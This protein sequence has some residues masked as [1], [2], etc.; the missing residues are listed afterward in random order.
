MGNWPGPSKP[1]AWM[2]ANSRTPPL[3]PGNQGVG[4]RQTENERMSSFSESRRKLRALVQP[5]EPHEDDCA[6]RLRLA[7]SMMDAGIEMTKLR[8]SRQFPME[9]EM[10][11]RQRLERWMQD[12][13][14]SDVFVPRPLA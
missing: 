8:L 4:A 6:S 13:P 2:L 12:Q 7:L 3:C 14:Y 1:M 9:T 5:Y 11:I 10:Q